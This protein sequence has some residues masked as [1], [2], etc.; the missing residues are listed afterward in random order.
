MLSLLQDIR[1]AVR[2][3]IDS[4]G[5]TL[6]TI[7]SLTCERGRWDRGGLCAHAFAA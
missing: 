3:L 4:L 1:Y 5:F 7:L 6:T 2:Q